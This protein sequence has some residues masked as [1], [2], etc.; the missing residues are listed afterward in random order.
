[1][2]LDIWN[3]VGLMVIVYIWVTIEERTNKH[4]LDN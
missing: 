2:L 1:M 3:I 4:G